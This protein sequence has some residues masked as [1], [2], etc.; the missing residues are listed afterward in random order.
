MTV[1]KWKLPGFTSRNFHPAATA[2]HPPTPPP[3]PFSVS[4]ALALLRDTSN[5]TPASS[6]LRIP[7]KNCNVV[8]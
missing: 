1:A 8:P 5:G 3:R 6:F 4:T 2:K 7:L